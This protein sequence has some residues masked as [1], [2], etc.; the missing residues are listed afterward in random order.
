MTAMQEF[1]V[2]KS[3]PRTF[4]IKWNG[5][6]ARRSQPRFSSYADATE[7]FWLEITGFVREM[8]EIGGSWK[9]LELCQGRRDG[10]P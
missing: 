2:P 10:T 5:F 3:M 1:V 9:G 8:G 6:A 4:A 7:C